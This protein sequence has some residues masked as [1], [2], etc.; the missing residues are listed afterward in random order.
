MNA[1][2]LLVDLYRRH[3]GGIEWISE[4]KGYLADDI[5]EQASSQG[6]PIDELDFLKVDMFDCW[7]P[8]NINVDVDDL[9]FDLELYK[10]NFDTKHCIYKVEKVTER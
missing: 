6:V 3:Y 7:I 1:D 4:Y 9:S 8:V 10:Y 5:R 2:K